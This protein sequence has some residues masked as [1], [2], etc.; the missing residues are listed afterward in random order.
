MNIQARSPN[1]KVDT[2]DGLVF[3]GEITQ[4]EVAL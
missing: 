4:F 1:Y 2:H 3:V